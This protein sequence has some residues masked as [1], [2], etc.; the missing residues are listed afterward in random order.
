MRKR[1]FNDDEKSDI[2][3][4]YRLG[5]SYTRISEIYKTDAL[6]IRRLLIEA[7]EIKTKVEVEHRK[8]STIVTG[9]PVEYE[10]KVYYDWTDAFRLAWENGEELAIR[11]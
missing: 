7:G 9:I 1:I 10:G 4:K 5:I 8:G 6:R 2:I 3:A 11:K